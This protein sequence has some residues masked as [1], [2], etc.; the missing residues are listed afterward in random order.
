MASY[1]RKFVKDFAKITAPL[2]SLADKSKTWLWNA[3]CELAFNTLKHRL[4]STP[5]L[6]LPRYD[7]EFILDVDASGDGGLGAQYYLKSSTTKNV[8]SR[9][10]VELSQRLKGNIAPLEEKCL[11]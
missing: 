1:Y 11:P 7:Q 2:H 8:W 5:M 3:K 10:P 4:T 6:I 9:M